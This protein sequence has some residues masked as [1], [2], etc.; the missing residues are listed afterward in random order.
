MKSLSIIVAA[1]NEEGNVADLHRQ[2]IE[3]CQDQAYDFEFILVDDG[4]TDKTF[5]VASTLSPAK[6]I[7]FRKN[8]GQTAAIDAGIKAAKK[9]Y[10]VTLDA[11]L[12]NDPND[13][14]AMIALLESMDL[15]VVSGWRRKRK[16]GFFKR[17]ISRGANLLRKILV[18]DNINDSGCSLK[19]FKKSCFEGISLY[20]EMHRFIPAVLK[21]K[22]FKIG[23]IEVNHR[24]RHS[25]KTKY[26]WR[27]MI[28]GFMDM[29]S[30]WFWNKYAARP[31]HLLGGIGL[32]FLL[33]G[34]FCG[35]MFLFHLFFGNRISESFW[36]ALMLFT[37]LNGINVFI[38]SLFGDIMMKNYFERSNTQPYS[39]K[40]VIEN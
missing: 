4:S 37:F 39:I 32:F 23:E 24:P 26:T 3:V 10:L 35:C 29:I 21:I 6:I 34:F 2:V 40:E 27:R 13:I 11:D 1:Y 7:R 17:F 12:Q 18:D 31:V 16:D 33:I 8:F 14:P 25:G 38:F 15:D 22:G 19:V 28:K 9:E 36:L 20:G 5:E 30:V